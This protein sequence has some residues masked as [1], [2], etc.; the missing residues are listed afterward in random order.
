MAL[1]ANTAHSSIDENGNL[2]LDGGA[3]VRGRLRVVGAFKVKVVNIATTTYTVSTS[4]NV[5][6]MSAVAARVVTLPDATLT[7]QDGRRITIKDIGNTTAAISIVGTAG[8]VDAG[9]TGTISTALGKATYV[10]D[11]SAWWSV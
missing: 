4:D 2:V 10:S 6:L 8:N 7:D 9:T 11:G 1:N 5:V 3:L